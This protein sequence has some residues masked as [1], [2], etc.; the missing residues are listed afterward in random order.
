MS[1]YIF[2]PVIAWLV[3]QLLKYLFA[4]FKNTSALT[5]HR[6]I[7]KSGDMPSS[8][9]AIVVSLLVVVGTKD[10]L[11]SGMFGVVAILAGIVLYDALNV[12]RAVGEQGQALQRLAS[13]GG[14][15][16][17]FFSAKGHTPLEVVAGSAIGLMVAGILL[18]FL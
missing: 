18:R 6:L 8:H 12:R 9:S 11:D 1:E 2:I 17:A 15:K 3:A 16:Y 5:D 7:Y 14:K 4:G 13:D 10:G